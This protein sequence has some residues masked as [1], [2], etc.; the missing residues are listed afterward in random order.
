M[1]NARRD[2][3]EILLCGPGPQMIAVKFALYSLVLEGFLHE[4]KS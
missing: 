4:G 3:M 2:K 1:K